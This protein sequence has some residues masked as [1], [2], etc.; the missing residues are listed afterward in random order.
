M[1][2]GIRDDHHRHRERR[3]RAGAIVTAMLLLSSCAG[4]SAARE[5][6]G[7][8]TTT[9]RH[10]EPSGRGRPNADPAATTVHFEV[11]GV[12]VVGHLTAAP[13]SRGAEPKPVIVMAHGLGLLQSSGLR[14]Y[15]ERFAGAGYPVLTF[16][17]RTFGES[18]GEPR[19][20]IDPAM[21]LEDWRAAIAYVRH[22]GWA[23]PDRVVLWGSSLS[24]GH[25]LALGA[26]DSRLG[27]IVSQ[28]PHVDG[29]A[30]V[31]AVDPRT[32]RALLGAAT[33]DVTAARHG[34]EPVT[35]PIVGEP[36]TP[37]LMSQPGSKAGYLALI[38]DDPGWSNATPARVV[39]TL[40][41]YSPG[42]H[43][44]DS[45]VPTFIGI[46]TH[47]LVTP[48]EPARAL[49]TQMGAVVEE[50][51]AGHF[52]VYRG[53]QFEAIVADELTFLRHALR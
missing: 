33:K 45:T 27:A 4:S 46:A 22:H 7:R 18:S 42:Q 38:G 5:S 14:P 25:V 17:Y 13:S 3:R 32:V 10:G 35:I 9:T 36:G 26:E 50:Y 16:D 24:G 41:G 31:A 15:V 43:A 51:D 28:V 21:Q 11:H 23:G 30:S 44:A 47:D 48:P 29:A 52:D 37:A 2:R 6:D 34:D 49:G 1:N 40:P 8:G 53:K 19:Q 39:G 20:L 12:D